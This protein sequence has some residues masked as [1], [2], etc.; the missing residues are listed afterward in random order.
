AILLTHVVL[1]A[2]VPFLALYTLWQ[3]LVSRNFQ[4]HKRIA[5]VTFPIWLYV[6][7]TGVVIYVML[8]HVAPAVMSAG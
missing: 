1:A 6:S 8:Y 3:A 4:R 5:R 7:V 2:A